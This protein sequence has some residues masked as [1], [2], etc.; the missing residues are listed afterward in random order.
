MKDRNGIWNS[1][2]DPSLLNPSG[3]V[4][5][6]PNWDH[7]MRPQQLAGVKPHSTP[8]ETVRLRVVEHEVAFAFQ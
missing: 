5:R 3:P 1:P 6:L 8:P 7:R 4:V 2:C